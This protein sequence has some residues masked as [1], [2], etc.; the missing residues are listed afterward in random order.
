[1]YP[2]FGFGE[3]SVPLHEPMPSIPLAGK[4]KSKLRSTPQ[5][6][7]P[8][9]KAS[10]QES[11][12]GEVLAADPNPSIGRK[13]F[14][15][16][17]E[18][19]PARYATGGIV[20][21]IG[22]KYY[23]KT[24]GHIDESEC[25][26]IPQSLPHDIDYCRFD[27]DSDEED[28]YMFQFDSD[29][30][31]RGSMTPEDNLSQADSFDGSDTAS[32]G[33]IAGPSSPGDRWRYPQSESLDGI[34]GAHQS[35]HSDDNM[36]G[37]PAL[38]SVGRL[39]H[40]SRAGKKPGLDYAFV[41]L[42][43]TFDPEKANRICADST[44][45]THVQIRGVEPI[46]AV[47]RDIVTVTASG[48]IAHGKIMPSA[49]YF[50][51]P[52]QKSLQKLYV[53]HLST[54]VVDGD[55]GADVVDVNTGNLYGHIVRGC[56]GTQI[57]YIVSAKDVFEDLK[58]RLGMAPEIV[59]PGQAEGFAKHGTQ[60]H[61]KSGSP[62]VPPQEQS[63]TQPDD[64]PSDDLWFDLTL[65]LFDPSD[66]RYQLAPPTSQLRQFTSYNPYCDPPLHT[67]EPTSLDPG[68][69][70]WGLEPWPEYGTYPLPFWFCDD[71]SSDVQRRDLKPVNKLGVI[72][73]G[74]DNPFNAQALEYHLVST[75]CGSF[76]S[77]TGDIVVASNV[78]C[79]ATT[80]ANRTI[81]LKPDGLP[82]TAVPPSWSLTVQDW[83]RRNL[84]TTGVN[85]SAT[86]KEWLPTVNLTQLIPWP[87]ITSL[88]YASGVGVYET[89][90]E[91]TSPNN[92]TRVF[93]SVGQVEGTFGVTLNGEEIASVEQF[94]NNDI[95]VTDL[96]FQGTNSIEIT[97]ATTLSNK[98]RPVRIYYLQ[99]LVIQARAMP[100]RA[101]I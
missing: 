18:N 61:Y 76:V 72:Y 2:E 21:R 82:A 94:G 50:R 45:N 48:G 26:P 89:T 22:D 77:S 19:E 87:N 29:I 33:L 17:T 14:V 36:G 91:L 25:G 64:E 53:V 34:D 28:D 99:A 57:T 15:S 70:T 80:S 30:T 51:N 62:Q 63:Y 31:S 65:G 3:S 68:Q 11:L 16:S 8:S 12:V 66:L 74:K 52:N 58:D 44:T 97:V 100:W 60:N 86:I 38:T 56:R 78:T 84:N 49:V 54:M 1:M 43:D 37:P 42:N 81:T 20:V 83:P 69:Q 27:D 46:A 23:Q 73:V 24:V 41:R 4:V 5:D 7:V 90:V 88:E 96:V 6:D 39:E 95:D 13:L 55:C 59:F 98:L 92:S 35:L 32:F 79:T 47:E 71:A 101:I 10:L 40:N 75:S 67:L 9:T 93:L 85:S